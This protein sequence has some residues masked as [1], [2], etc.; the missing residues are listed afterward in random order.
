MLQKEKS[1]ILTSIKSPHQKS[2]KISFQFNNIQKLRL[3]NPEKN[4]K[5]TQ[6]TAE[7]LAEVKLKA[8]IEVPL[9]LL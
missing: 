6:V 8:T 4:K 1:P 2:R 5:M 7:V 3:R 9:M